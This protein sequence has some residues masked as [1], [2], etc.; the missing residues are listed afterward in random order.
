MAKLNTAQGFVNVENITEDVLISKDGFVFGFL[1]VKSKNISLLKEYEKRAYYEG[2]TG[3]LESIEGIF[4]LISIPKPLDVLG[5]L[6]ELFK[7][8][9]KTT[10]HQKL[11]LIDGEL[12]ALNE[13][14]LHGAKEPVIYLK[15][16]EKA[17]KFA[18]QN[19]KKRLSTIK[20][21]LED[22]GAICEHL[23]SQDITFLCKTFSDL[24]V[25]TEDDLD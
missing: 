3:A 8:R 13:L 16:W 20:S 19:L 14:A 11:K 10:N 17:N 2:L 12:K 18:I 21:V 24:T 22:S 6:D 25:Y 5:M 9:K 7:L 4:Q 15:I 23:S 1:F